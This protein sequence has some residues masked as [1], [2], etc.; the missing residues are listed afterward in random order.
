MTTG[1]LS[2]LSVTDQEL[3]LRDSQLDLQHADFV[4]QANFYSLVLLESTLV[5][6]KLIFAF[7]MSLDP[8]DCG[9]WPNHKGH[10]VPTRDSLYLA[11][12]FQP[13]DSS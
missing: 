13:D 6:A 9:K 3:A 5:V 11:V 4:P 7:D 2:I 10:F 1:N 12:T 8:T